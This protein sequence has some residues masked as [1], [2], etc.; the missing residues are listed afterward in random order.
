MTPEYYI[1]EP[2]GVKI[3]HEGRDGFKITVF[4]NFDKPILRLHLNKAFIDRIY[5]ET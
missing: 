3:E 4:G 5:D 2:S 1:N